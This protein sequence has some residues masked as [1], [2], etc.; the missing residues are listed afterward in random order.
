MAERNPHL[1]DAVNKVFGEI[2]PE[3]TAD[4]RDV[5]SSSPDPEHDRWLRD[6]VPPHHD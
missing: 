2:L 4:E 3:T 6:N 5:D 1:S